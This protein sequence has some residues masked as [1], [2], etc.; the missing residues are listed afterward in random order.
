L[1][2]TYT[3]SVKVPPISVAILMQSSP[4]FGSIIGP[5]VLN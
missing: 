4:F 2:S 1:S 3:K 5:L